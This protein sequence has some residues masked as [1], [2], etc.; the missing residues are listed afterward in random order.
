M[1]AGSCRKFLLSSALRPGSRCKG[2]VGGVRG[3]V[4]LHVG[5]EF[6]LVLD[7][8]FRR[9]AERGTSQSP[10]PV[11]LVSRRGTEE[12]DPPGPS[13]ASEQNGK[14]LAPSSLAILRHF[15]RYDLHLALLEVQVVPVPEVVSHVV[16]LDGE[17][18]VVVE[19]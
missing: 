17:L 8:A 1:G 11:L 9:N 16:D 14:F 7:E 10:E 19:E 2:R 6:S 18:V 5:K 12:I 3:E 13:S 15:A 4:V